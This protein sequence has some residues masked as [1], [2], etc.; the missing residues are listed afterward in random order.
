MTL[1][2]IGRREE[3]DRMIAER[4]ARRRIEEEPVLA[5]LREVGVDVE[6]CLVLDQ[7]L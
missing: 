6:S 1:N 5:E 4:A 2:I 3:R 7:H